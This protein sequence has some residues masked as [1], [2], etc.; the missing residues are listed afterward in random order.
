VGIIL[1]LPLGVLGIGILLQ[2]ALGR[3]LSPGGKGWLAFATSLVALFGVLALLPTI[4][5][6]APAQGTLFLWDQNI[7]I[8]LYV[9]GL[10]LIFAVMATGIGSAIL[11]YSVRY[12]E[13]EPAGLTRFY[14]LMLA[15]IGG[16]VCMVYSANL[17]LVY[18]SWE[19]IGLCSYFLVGFW[20][21][22]A[23][24]VVGARK[25][26]VMTHLPG[27]GLLAAILILYSQT[28]TFLWT[29]PAIRAAF[30][31]G[32]FLLMLV[33]AMAKSVMFPLHTWIPEAMNAPTPVS[34]L[35]HSACYVK[36]G[37][38]LIAR[39]Y[40]MAVWPHSWNVVVLALGCAT[41]IVGALF[42]L[43]QTD[44]KRLLAFSTISQLGYII[45]AL[46]LGTNLGIAAGLFYT[47]SHG[48]FKGTLFLCAGAVQHAT[49]TR[50]MRRLG[51]LAAKMPH[52]S[53]IWLI[54]A[55]AIIGV[56]LTN[57]FVAKWLLLDAALDANQTIV[58]I[59]AWGISVFTAFY[60]LKATVST[61]YG[62]MP[63][64]LQSKEIHEAGPAMLAGM[65][66][67]AG[68]CILFGLAPQIL[69]QWLVAPAVTGLG[70]QWAVAPSW[71]G[72]Q[73][74]SA[75]VQV[76]LGAGITLIALLVGWLVYILA[77]PA[78]AKAAPVGLFTG[79]DPL[80]AAAGV[81]TVDFAALAETNFTPVYK[82][83]DPDP[84]YLG[85]WNGIKGMAGSLDRLMC[86]VCDIHPL[87]AT[88]LLALAVLIAAW[89]L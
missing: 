13:Y 2:L 46:G 39:M 53:R 70:F 77:R 78:K 29:D 41:I 83:S 68:L 4:N 73:T 31:S 38:Y 50:D 7:P 79:G 11:L 66:F 21:K 42:A 36:A 65:G 47:L 59:V 57:G 9:D 30:T 18:I 51:G 63:T 88:L 71:L 84:V 58:V 3:I 32:I 54:A 26:L 28:G 10:S 40:S 43:V 22:E 89:L 35:L 19:V 67:L 86:P 44:L 64:W 60:M 16:L 6:G 5:S 48:L 24:A 69:M 34:A 20:Y 15:F 23:A 72:L 52:T 62:E 61:F 1:V 75:G 8:Q 56:P 45:T 87:L 27:Y 14:I 12:M 80:P 55:A 25:V 85:I 37:V 76:T 17:M 81:S 33:A 82:A 49:G 74:S